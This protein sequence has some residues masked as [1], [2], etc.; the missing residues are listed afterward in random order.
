M[1][2]AAAVLEAAAAPE[3][4]AG[5]DTTSPLGAK[6][7]GTW[8]HAR[9]HVCTLGGLRGAVAS[10]VYWLDQMMSNEDGRVL[11]VGADGDEARATTAFTP[12]GFELPRIFEGPRA[13]LQAHSQEMV[14]RLGESGWPP[15]IAQNACSG[16]R[17]ES[18][19]CM[20]CGFQHSSTWV[21]DGVCLG[22]EHRVRA[23]GRC[24]FGAGGRH[25]ARCSPHAWC[26]HDLRCLVCDSWSCARCRFHQGDGSDVAALVGTLRPAA[27]FLDFDR[28]LCS[29]KGGSP[30]KGNHSIDDELLG[31]C[32]QM[33]GRVHVVTRNA[34]V[35]DIARFLAERGLPSLPVHRVK[36]PASKA[37]VVCDPRWTATPDGGG[38]L[39]ADAK[40]PA[41][42]CG[43]ESAASL[44]VGAEAEPPAGG[45]AAALLARPP[46][47]FV[48]DS[49]AEHFDP[50]IREAK[51]VVRFLFARS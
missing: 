31:L 36:R 17:S 23:A 49:I 2:E 1:P 33:E 9:K 22:C 6:A 20:H 21:R 13:T 30:L 18:Q 26:P 7:V 14:R 16:R 29:T 46:V 19:T 8:V 51:H 42:A 39:A 45:A 47:C 12:P 15:W 40:A 48:D 37:D 43:A 44:V 5:V 32:S 25:A 28:T 27:L 50:S 11:F 10:T 41:A 24:P 38:D 34:H 35:D 4:A 3:A